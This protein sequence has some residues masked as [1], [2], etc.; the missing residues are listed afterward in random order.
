M[1]VVC[2][3]VGSYH[4]R[5]KRQADDGL[6]GNGDEEEPR[7]LGGEELELAPARARRDG[8]SHGWFSIVVSGVEVGGLIVS[9]LVRCASYG[10]VSGQERPA[11]VLSESQFGRW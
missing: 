8:W 2:R 7:P 6:D 10:R 11:G 3:V 1:A 9:L 4:L 5:L